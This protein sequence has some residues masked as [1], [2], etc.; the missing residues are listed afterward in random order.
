TITNR[1]ELDVFLHFRIKSFKAYLRLENVQSLIPGNGKNNFA[2]QNYANQ[3][4]WFRTGIW[5]NFVN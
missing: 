5:W 4:L 1:P 2:L 3:K